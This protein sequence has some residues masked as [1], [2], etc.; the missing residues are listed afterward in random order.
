MNHIYELIEARNYTP[1]FEILKNEQYFPCKAFYDGL[2]S[3]NLVNTLQVN[4]PDN[5]VS[6]YA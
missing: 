6:T 4:A 5:K 2:S 3:A 1:K